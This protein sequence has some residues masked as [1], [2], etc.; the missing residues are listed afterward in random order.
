MA[1]N[2][3]QSKQNGNVQPRLFDGNVLI[4]IGFLCTHHV[5]H[6]P[7]LPLGHQI[8]PAQIRYPGASGEAR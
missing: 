7:N 8:V 5:G 4:V 3:V 6:R 1:V 2:H